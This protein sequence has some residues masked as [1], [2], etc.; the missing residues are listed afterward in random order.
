MLCQHLFKQTMPYQ[1]GYPKIRTNK[2]SKHFTS[3]PQHLQENTND[4]NKR[5]N[6]VFIKKTTKYR[7]VQVPHKSRKRMGKVCCVDGNK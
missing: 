4:S 7:T 1:K 3:L 6:N 2:N 5:R